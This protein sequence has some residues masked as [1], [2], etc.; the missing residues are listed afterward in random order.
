MNPK[1]RRV[2]TST[3]KG[4]KGTESAQG[5]LGTSKVQTSLYSL[6]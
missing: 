5:S 1:F 6:N 2:M 3:V 4:V